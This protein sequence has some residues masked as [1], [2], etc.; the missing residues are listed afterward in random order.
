M[1]CINFYSFNVRGLR[2]GKKREEIFQWLKT[3]F[4][5]KDSIFFLQETHSVEND[6][7]NWQKEWG[8][9]SNARL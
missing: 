3:F 9:D 2:D 5:E 8:A 7:E 1:N 4:A 6:L